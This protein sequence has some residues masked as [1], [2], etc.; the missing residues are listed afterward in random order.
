MAI[1]RGKKLQHILTHVVLIVVAGF[2]AINLYG[3]VHKPSAQRTSA[4]PAAASTAR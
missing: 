3:H 1:A 2:L 4:P